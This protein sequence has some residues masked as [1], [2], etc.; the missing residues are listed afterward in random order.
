MSSD[1]YLVGF[2]SSHAS[3]QSALARFSRVQL[4]HVQVEARLEA[5][6][7]ADALLAAAEL[8][9]FDFALLAAAAGVAAF[10]LT[11]LLIA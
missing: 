2:F 10:D 1:V 4:R 11:L 5:A 9:L 6:A 8:E 7:E 3:Q